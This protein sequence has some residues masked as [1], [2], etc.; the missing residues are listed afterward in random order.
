MKLRISP[1]IKKI[2][3]LTNARIFGKLNKCMKYELR[4]HFQQ[5]DKI[6]KS[7]FHRSFNNLTSANTKYLFS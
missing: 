7:I 3:K 4:L 6:L 1:G 2:N 5:L